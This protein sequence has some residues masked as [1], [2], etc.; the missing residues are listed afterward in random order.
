MGLG[1]AVARQPPGNVATERDEVGDG[2]HT[3]LVSIFS[4]HRDADGVLG[5]ARCQETQP[6]LT[7]RRPQ[8]LEVGHIPVGSGDRYELSEDY[9]RQV[10]VAITH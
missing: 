5:A 6:F 10:D 2:R 1:W 9:R 7:K 8:T 3:G 4:E